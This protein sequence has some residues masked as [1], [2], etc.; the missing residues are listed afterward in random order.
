MLI[1]EVKKRAA[2]EG[3]R[4]PATPQR[5]KPEL[6]IVDPLLISA[7][8]SSAESNSFEPPFFTSVAER[9]ALPVA[10]VRRGARPGFRAQ[11]DVAGS[12]LAAIGPPRAF[13]RT[14]RA[15]DACVPL[16][17]VVAVERLEVGRILPRGARGRHGERL[18]YAPLLRI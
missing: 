6:R 18:L 15:R 3:M 12:C 8:A 16:I 10:N 17:A 5:P 13:A 1:V 2:I 14:R 7:T 11:N 9:S 4:I